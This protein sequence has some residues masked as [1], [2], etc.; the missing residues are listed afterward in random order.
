MNS[1]IASSFYSQKNIL[2]TRIN[3]K[4][5]KTINSAYI[6]QKMPVVTNYWFELVCAFLFSEGTLQLLVFR[7]VWILAI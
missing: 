3:I 1:S 2:Q 6:W 4:W 5:D 7:R